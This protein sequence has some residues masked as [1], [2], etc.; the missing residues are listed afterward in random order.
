LQNPSSLGKRE[1]ADCP[2][3]GKDSKAGE[4]RKM[5]DMLRCAQ[6]CLYLR[7]DLVN[8]QLSDEAGKNSISIQ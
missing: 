2:A 7:Q 8:H 1:K 6:H 4:V 5:H 3:T